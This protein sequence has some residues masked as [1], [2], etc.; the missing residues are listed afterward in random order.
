MHN[1]T[2]SSLIPNNSIPRL[3]IPKHL[4]LEHLQIFKLNGP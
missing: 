1:Q 3:I 4:Y 2:L